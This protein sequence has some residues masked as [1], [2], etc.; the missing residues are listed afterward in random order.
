M[1]IDKWVPVDIAREYN[2]PRK[3]IQ[4]IANF[5]GLY[6]TVSNI[7]LRDKIIKNLELGIPIEVISDN[8]CINIDLINDI[9]DIVNEIRDFKNGRSLTK[10][11]KVYWV[12]RRPI[13]DSEKNP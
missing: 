5:L 7:A 4:K 6:N 10:I 8:C 2:I 1:L 13:T 9:S 11:A 3:K 12:S